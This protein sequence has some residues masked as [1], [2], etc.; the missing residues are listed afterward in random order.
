MIKRY[1][2]RVGQMMG[3]LMAAGGSAIAVGT[4]GAIILLGIL[5]GAI[6]GMSKVVAVA[7]LLLVFLPLLILFGL[8]PVALGGV[9]LFASDRAKKEAIRDTFFQLL[10]AKKGRITLVEFAR[11]A[12]LEPVIARQYLDRWARECNADFDVTEAGE[13]QYVFVYEAPGS[14]PGGDAPFQAWQVWMKE[15]I[16]LS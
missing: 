12:E 16:N 13:I 14:L 1:G 5:L 11:A 7:V 4:L 9:M 3:W 8:L 15:R 6:L 10:K 2:S